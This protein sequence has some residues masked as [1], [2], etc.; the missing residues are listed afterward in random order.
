MLKRILIPG[1]AIGAL[2]LSASTAQAASFTLDDFSQPL[3]PST[4]AQGTLV[5]NAIPTASTPNLTGL[6]TL[7]GSRRI[8]QTRIVTSP[9][10]SNLATGTARVN[11]VTGEFVITQGVNLNSTTVLRYDAN[12]AGLGAAGNWLTGQNA[13]DLFLIRVPFVDSYMSMTMR[14]GNGSLNS[15]TQTA[16][17][18]RTA[19]RNN[20]TNQ[21]DFYTVYN[22]A[23]PGSNVLQ[24]SPF[25]L[26]GTA[27]FELMSF[28]DANPNINLSAVSFVELRLNG[29]VSFDSRIDYI[30]G[31]ELPEG[32]SLPFLGVFGGL[33][34]VKLVLLGRGKGED[35]WKDE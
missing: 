8:T 28:L 22:P 3:P 27:V 23:T 25:A 17:V 11:T 4:N 21:I 12:G 32:S 20:N 19:V 15:P 7:G 10:P 18:T 14:I 35:S 31:V 6:N 13:I 33:A 30:E 2:T 29:A 24:N 26:P 5:R 1:F 34:V 16:S 9:P